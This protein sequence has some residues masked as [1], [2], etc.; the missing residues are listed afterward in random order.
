MNDAS[1][2]QAQLINQVFSRLET[3]YGRYGW[4]HLEEPYEVMV[5]AILVQN[6]SWKN[7]EKALA[8][9]A[10][11]FNPHAI[12]QMPVADLAE[13]IRP[14]GYYNQKAL[15]LKAITSWF[16]HYRYSIQQVRQVDQQTLRQQLLSVKGVGNETADAILVYAIRKP[17]FVI[18]AYTRRIFTRNGLAVPASYDKFQAL[19]ESVI[20]QDNDTYA[21]YH[22]LM[23]D[24]AQQFCHK[25]PKCSG[26]P[27]AQDCLG[28]T[29]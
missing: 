13:L 17:S 3:H 20:P 29:G 14:S 1:P 6:T 5:G 24:H 9:L 27:L 11:H 16:A 21:Y 28:V 18:D 12:A 2:Q 8:N 4:W 22:G 25:T 23:V 26:C 7:V 15:K 19:L 10:E